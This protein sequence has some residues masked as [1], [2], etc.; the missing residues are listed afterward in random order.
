MLV[1]QKIKSNYTIWY[2][3]HY[4][5]IIRH[6]KIITFRSIWKK[7]THGF[8]FFSFL[9]TTYDVITVSVYY[10]NLL[11]LLLLFLVTNIV[12]ALFVCWCFKA[13][14]DIINQYLLRMYLCMSVNINAFLVVICNSN[15]L[16]NN[17]SPIMI[18][19]QTSLIEIL[20]NDHN[21]R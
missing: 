13:A 12:G 20:F 6:K 11:L 4:K 16:R 18:N 21:A 9:E 17:A 7:R 8:I 14:L 5:Y 15:L 2:Q 1:G 10:S 19:R 3:Y